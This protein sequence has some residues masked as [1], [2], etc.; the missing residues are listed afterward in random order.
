MVFKMKKYIKDVYCKKCNKHLA[1]NNKSG[2]CYLHK[3]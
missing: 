3:K 1:W 2:Y